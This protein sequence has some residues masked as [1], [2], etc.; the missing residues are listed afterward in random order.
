MWRGG[1]LHGASAHAPRQPGEAERHDPAS[2]RRGVVMIF[3][4]GYLRP[5]QNFHYAMPQE[6]HDVGTFENDPVPQ[7]P[8][9][10]SKPV[11]ILLPPPKLLEICRCSEILRRTS[12][13]VVANKRIV[14]ALS[15]N[16]VELCKEAFLKNES[17]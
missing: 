8:E 6:V 7:T 9:K 17:Y 2:V 11:D 12:T 1:T 4:L 3:N 5:E 15:E 13:F 16:Y 10:S 14:I